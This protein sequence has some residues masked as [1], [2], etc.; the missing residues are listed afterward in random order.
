MP[1]GRGTP[2]TGSQR[3]NSDDRSRGANQLSSPDANEQADESARTTPEDDPGITGDGQDMEILK[4][5]MG[6]DVE[7]DGDDEDPQRP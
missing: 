6:A 5:L 3:D 1:D 4:V 2:E 7:L